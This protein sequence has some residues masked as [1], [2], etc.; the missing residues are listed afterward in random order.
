MNEYLQYQNRGLA[1]TPFLEEKR[2]IEI[3]SYTLEAVNKK[4]FKPK[5]VDL[6]FESL[7]THV[8]IWWKMTKTTTMTN[9]Y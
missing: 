6:K 3:K 1:I 4:T 8:Q 2:F 9:D 5:H 7:A